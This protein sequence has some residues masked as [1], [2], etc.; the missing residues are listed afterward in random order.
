VGGQVGSVWGEAD[1]TSWHT[2]PEDLHEFTLE[3]FDVDGFSGGIFAGYD[4]AVGNSVVIGIEGSWNF[5]SADDRITVIEEEIYEWGA[6]VELKWDASLRLRA[7]KQMSDYLLYF[8]GGIAWTEVNVLGFTSWDP[9]QGT[10]HDATLSGWT[11]GAGLERKVHESLRFRIQYNYS[12]YGDDVWSLPLP[13][14]VD[15]GMVEFK[16]QTLMAG[17]SYRF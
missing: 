2:D 14:D 11:I 10:D 4:W 1:T 5:A 17:L 6:E 7:G 12:D 9:D 16:N 8:T 3:G 13:N 15:R